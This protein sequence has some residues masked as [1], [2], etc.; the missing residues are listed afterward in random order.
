MT[1]GNIEKEYRRVE[2]GAYGM[3]N[4]RILVLG[5]IYI[6]IYV[7]WMNERELSR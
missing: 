1:Y 7:E 5:D 4:V 3:G 2:Q 6:Y